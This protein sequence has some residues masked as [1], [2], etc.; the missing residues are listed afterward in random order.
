VLYRLRCGTELR[1]EDSKEKRWKQRLPFIASRRIFCGRKLLKSQ[2]PR[3]CM[4]YYRKWD[5]RKST[6]HCRIYKRFQHT[7]VS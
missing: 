6:A 7:S 2:W 4:T 3:K 5:Q 1:A